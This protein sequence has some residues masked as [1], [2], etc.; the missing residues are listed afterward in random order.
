MAIAFDAV[1]EGTAGANPS[2]N[3]TCTGTDLILFVQ[4]GAS[5]DTI[6]GVTYNAVAMTEITRTTFPGA[7]HAGLVLFYLVNPTT[8]TNSVAVTSSNAGTNGISQS[9]TGAAQTGQPD[10]F[11]VNN[12]GTGT[13]SLTTSTTVVGANCWLVGGSSNDDG[14]TVGAGAGTT[15]RADNGQGHAMGD[16]NA[17]VSTG[18]QSLI[19]TYPTAK[20]FKG[21]I[22]SFA[23]SGG[24]SKEFLSIVGAG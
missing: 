24:A 19:F 18:S 13:T 16:S 5:I 4:V 1:A 22:A 9:Y 14:G 6:T 2:W 23:P 21:I 12:N 11:N 7:G 20:L 3:H 8:G 10:S 15:V 17:T